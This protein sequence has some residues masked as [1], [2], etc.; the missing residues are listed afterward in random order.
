MVSQ[1]ESP[2]V[3]FPCIVGL[4]PVE[5]GTSTGWQLVFSTRPL[6]TATVPPI[7]CSS[8]VLRSGERGVKNGPS[9]SDGV[10]P[11]WSSQGSVGG[12]VFGDRRLAEE[13]LSRGKAV[14]RAKNRR[15]VVLIGVRDKKLNVSVG[16]LIGFGRA[17]VSCGKVA[18][19]PARLTYRIPVDQILARF[20][21]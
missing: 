7:F 3:V 9:V 20:S 17:V 8:R 1:P 13:K 4:P 21:I 15:R 16:Y 19:Y 14:S 12:S 5:Q 18:F 6:S 11:S 2:V 10:G